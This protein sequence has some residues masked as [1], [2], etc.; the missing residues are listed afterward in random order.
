MPPPDD[1]NKSEGGL[2]AVLEGAAKVADSGVM[3]DLLGRS[4]KAVGDYYGE[5][6]EEYF[7]QRRMNRRK[8]IRDHENQVA[9]VIGEP[10]SIL[11]RPERGSAIERW[12]EVAADVPLEDAER[13]ALFEAVLA[14]IFSTNGTSDF[15]DV[16]ERLSSSGMRVLLNAP[17]TKGFVPEEG[18]RLSFERLQSLGLARTL[19]LRQALTV[20]LAWVVGTAAG[21]L[22]LFSASARYLPHLLAVEFIL[23]AAG[24]S[25]LALALGV[26]ILSTK[27]R[28]TELG[29]LLQKS[30]R[31]FY[32]KQLTLKRSLLLSVV[33]SS[34]W[35]WLSV[36]LLLVCALPFA[37][38]RYTPWRMQTTPSTVIISSP[39][40][41]PSAAPPPRT[42]QPPTLPSTPAQSAT[43]TADDVRA[44]IDVWRSVN[45]QVANIISITNNGQAIVA[46]WPQSVA[47][48]STG[49]ADNL[50]QMKTAISQRRTS[51]Q[52]LYSFYQKFPNVAS[53]LDQVSKAGIFDRL[54]QACDSFEREVRNLPKPPP[55]N[56]ENTLRP[57]AGELKGAVQAMANWASDTRNFANVQ[58]QELSSIDLK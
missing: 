43:M 7:E 2:P 13:A 34:P 44:L 33:P 32:G 56:F 24:I 17:S 42:S 20:I 36:A 8:N 46:N 14:Q 4:F 12:A 23:E 3:K 37:L 54:Y 49:L 1:D 9:Q 38:E 47:G 53:T 27:Y 25:A 45:E 15:Q 22:I 10:V 31:R 51:L 50:F 6:V 11:G 26:A 57:Y 39:P 18:D 55:K 40:T 35:A 28:L 52:S 30:A 48:N 41:S 16:A 58:S 29:R 5:Q 19:D 21:V